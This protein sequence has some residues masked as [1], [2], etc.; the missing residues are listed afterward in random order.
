LWKGA[1]VFL[2]EGEETIALV[3]GYCRYAWIGLWIAAGAPL[4]FRKMERRLVKP[5]S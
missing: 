5:E 1:K 2:P 4:V 3:A